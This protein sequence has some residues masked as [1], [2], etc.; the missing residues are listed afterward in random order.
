MILLFLKIIGLAWLTCAQASNLLIVP[1]LDLECGNYEGIG[2]LH[3]NSQG[4]I[5][6]AF[7]EKTTSPAEVILLGGGVFKKVE[8]LELKT[9]VGFYV[10]S[11]IHGN[12]QPYVFTYGLSDAGGD[13][14]AQD[15]IRLTRKEECGLERKYGE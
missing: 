6:L 11:P 5:I 12:E 2:T 3:R 13:D 15:S 1:R 14:L 9:K 8:R 7:N 4:M 10:P